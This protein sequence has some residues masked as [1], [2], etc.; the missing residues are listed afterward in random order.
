MKANQSDPKSFEESLKALEGIVRGLEQGTLPLEE[1]L[2]Q[3]TQATRYLKF[4]YERLSQAEKSVQLLRGVDASGTAA[5]I[6]LDDEGDS[7][8]EK[9]AGRGKRRSARSDLGE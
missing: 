1:S 9:Q 2:E 3:Y 5:T 6:A 7:L 8:A 4:C